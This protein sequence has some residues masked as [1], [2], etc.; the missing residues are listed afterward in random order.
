MNWPRTF[1]PLFILSSAVCAQAYLTGV[2][3]IAQRPFS[4]A[5]VEHF[6]ISIFHINDIHA[7]LDEITTSGTDCTNPALGC[8]GGYARIKAAVD[9]GRRAAANS[10]LLNMGDEFQGTLFYG[11]YGGEKIAETLNEMHFDAMTLGNHEFDRGD[12]YL[13]QFLANLSMP[14]VCANVHSSNPTINST[15]KPYHFF[16]QYNL[17]VIGL[18]TNTIPLTSNSDDS[19]SFDDPISSAQYWVD[20]VYKW[21]EG[22]KRVVL[23]THVGYD[24]DLQ[25]ARR[26]RGVYLI[27]GAH[28]HTLLGD[29][30]GAAGP[31]PTIRRNL[32]GEQVLVVTAYR[33]GEYLG[34]IDVEFDERGKIV[35]FEGKPIH[36][37]NETAQDSGLQNQ[38]RAWRAPFDAFAG[39]V[40]GTTSLQLKHDGCKTG[41]C[42]FGDVVCDAMVDYR[43]N[44]VT[45]CIFNGGGIRVTLGPGNITRG[46][47]L[48]ALPFGNAVA[49]VEM[50]G[51][52]LWD[53]LKGAVSGVAAHR[54]GGAVITFAQV[55]S[56]M[57]VT[58][59]PRT[60]T[61]I[62]LE[63]GD[64]R[65]DFGRLYRIVTLDY[66]AAG[67]DN[68]MAK[69]EEGVVVLDAVDEVLTAY[70]ERVGSVE[71]GVQDRVVFTDETVPRKEDGGVSSANYAVVLTF[72]G[73]FS[74][75]VTRPLFVD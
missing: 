64:E 16:P 12:A 14:V 44:N 70:I 3:R 51:R 27:I 43:H 20:Y 13:G 62:D 75:L 40:I 57:R 50:T 7:H 69:R 36:L 31:Y 42:T 15:V 58:Y 1:K 26:T 65:V 2:G 21:E 73:I 45:G 29:M 53:V 46:D 28:S 37:T 4:A 56:G 71:V 17:A 67:G 54:A 25:L 68:I 66:V 41:E 32:D 63:I 8:Y 55:S 60:G 19:T 5:K 24:V 34:H 61:L 48:G 30:K 52:E 72:I 22:V 18:T 38:I 9:A 59:N 47:V 35:A 6:N 10:L 49:E 11:Y 74:A 39:E 23:M 33:Y